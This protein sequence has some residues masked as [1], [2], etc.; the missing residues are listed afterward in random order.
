MAHSQVSIGKL[1]LVGSPARA[2]D[3]QSYF[4]PHV[5]SHGAALGFITACLAGSMNNYSKGQE[6]EADRRWK[7]IEF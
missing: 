2:D 7:P 1:V 3:Q 4:S 5:P 6:V